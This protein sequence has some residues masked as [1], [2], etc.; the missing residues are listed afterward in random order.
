MAK[1]VEAGHRVILATGTRGELG[2]IVVPDMDTPDNHRRL[3]EIRAGELERAMG[4]PRRDRVGEPRLSRLRDDGHGRQPR[5]ALVLAG[6]PR[7]GGRPADLAGAALP[8]GRHDDLQRVRR[9]RPPR[10]HPDPR[11]RGP[12]V[13][14]G[15]RPGLVSGAARGD[16]ARRR[17]RRRSSTIRRSRRRSGSGWRERM[18]EL[19]SEAVLV[20]AGRRDARADRRVRGIRREDARPRRADHDLDRRLAARRSRPSGTRSTST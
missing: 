18:E 13:R 15:R 6:R 8:A 20:A 7:R 19:G 12:G 9:L 3:G 1:A 2:E 11:R 17:G 10:P 16:R 4:H 5:P 14:A